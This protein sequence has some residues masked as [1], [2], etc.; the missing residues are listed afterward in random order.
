MILQR[1][2]GEGDGSTKYAKPGKGR[3]GG[4]AQKTCLR[5]GR[6]GRLGGMKVTRLIELG[7]CTYMFCS[8]GCKQEQ[9]VKE[10]QTA[11]EMYE[12][13]RA[14]LQPNAEHDS[15][16]YEEA[17]HWLRR[18]AEAGYLQAQTD[19]GGIYLEGGKVGVKP[20]GKEALKWFS[21][22]AAQGSKEA[23]VYMG[24]IHARGMDVPKNEQLARTYW[25]DAAQAG[26]AEAQLY[27]GTSGTGDKPADAQERLDWLR[28][29]V[30]AGMPGVAA[31][32]ACALGNLYITG[33]MGVEKNEQ[34][35]ARWYE[36]AARGG[37]MRAQLVYGIML[38]QGNILPKDEEKGMSYIRM[39][40]GQDNPQAISLL[41]HLLRHGGNAEA[42]E[43]EAAAWEERLKKR[44]SK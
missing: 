15:S 2:D 19:L 35:A 11:Q 42:N 34:E 10:P 24:L 31:R 5:W 8:V 7:V 18:S 32:A 41:I 14:L 13:V 39:S 12:R 27:M 22:A 40:A 37:D 4:R 38:L 44:P 9:E 28:R 33:K 16:E 3:R 25:R 1:E 36:I 43:K 23:L 20:D 30:G 6:G 26:I 17:L 21:M 29:A